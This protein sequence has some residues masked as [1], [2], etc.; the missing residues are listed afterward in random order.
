MCGAPPRIQLKYCEGKTPQIV[1]RALS[2]APRNLKRVQTNVEPSSRDS[3]LTFELSFIV[4]P[5][6]K[7]SSAPATASR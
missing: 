2:E 7:D 5:C 3:S 4:M 6:Q 1:S